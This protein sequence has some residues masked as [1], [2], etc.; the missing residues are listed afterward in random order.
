M[1]V[2][3][4][5]PPFEWKYLRFWPTL[6]TVCRL[7]YLIACLSLGCAIRAE[8]PQ[9]DS[10]TALLEKDW[11]LTLR[12]G[13]VV[14]ACV[15]RG[16]DYALVDGRATFRDIESMKTDAD[17]LLSL[18]TER[19]VKHF[20]GI[21]RLNIQPAL[22]NDKQL[23]ADDFRILLSLSDLRDLCI[24]D[25]GSITDERVETRVFSQLEALR[26]TLRGKTSAADLIR[27]LPLKQLRVVG[28]NDDNFVGIMSAI[29]ANPELEVLG[30]SM[31]HVGPRQQIDL[32]PLVGLARLKSLKIQNATIDP[33]QLGQLKHLKV[34]RLCNCRF[35]SSGDV[36]FRQP[37]LEKLVL[38]LQLL[39]NLRVSQPV[40][41]VGESLKSIE[42]WLPS[43][44]DLPLF[45]NTPCDLGITLGSTSPSLITCYEARSF[46]GDH[47]IGI[48]GD[49]EVKVFSTL[50]RVK[51]LRITGGNTT[52]YVKI[53]ESAVAALVE[54]TSIE[55]LE[56]EGEIDGPVLPAKSERLQS[57]LKHLSLSSFPPQ[58]R[59]LHSVM[60]GAELES[61]S[62]DFP[63]V[64]QGV[65]RTRRLKSHPNLKSLEL[66][67][68]VDG[69]LTSEIAMSLN[70]PA[71][72]RLTIDDGVIAAGEIRKL[73][74]AAPN[75]EEVELLDCTFVD[76]REGLLLNE[77]QHLRQVSV[78]NCE[79]SL[80]AL[81]RL[82][83]TVLRIGNR[84]DLREMEWQP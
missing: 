73:I 69:D 82:N 20:P 40:V 30:L 18:G 77:L 45:A 32:S 23:T 4:R 8:D 48:L 39:D 50:K 25:V 55:S 26:V 28:S 60:A 3:L 10:A 78:I 58:S 34:L 72:H 41:E 14:A 9:S 74:A 62:V 1:I 29:A 27:G 64:P 36:I 2:F 84:E 13:K 81:L 66:R 44:R 12:N 59:L 52:G 56:I 57:R 65:D 17:K 70:S 33:Q 76:E 61:L 71:L 22:R 24:E 16:G 53:S 79:V 7:Q 37:T 15:L 5:S 21:R 11:D 83:A 6:I 75:L 47:V 67:Y 68:L 49:S 80:Q 31:R 46:R 54:S 42:L 38:E 35:T 63:V 43:F 51:E 19:F